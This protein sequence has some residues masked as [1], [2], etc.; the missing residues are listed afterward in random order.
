MSPTIR[1][2]ALS[3]TAGAPVWPAVYYVGK[4]SDKLSGTS[5]EARSPHAILGDFDRFDVSPIFALCGLVELPTSRTR[6][7][8][9][10][11]LR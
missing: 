1:R 4:L 6:M 9:I 7:P 10:P 11:G 2:A 3:G 8:C 5:Q